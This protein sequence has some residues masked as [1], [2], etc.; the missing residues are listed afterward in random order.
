[1]LEDCNGNCC[2][3][4]TCRVFDELFPN[5]LKIGPDVIKG[6]TAFDGNTGSLPGVV[7]AAFGFASEL[8]QFSVDETKVG[9]DCLTEMND[10]D[11]FACSPRWKPATF[12]QIA[13]FIE[14]NP[15]GLWEDES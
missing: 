3:G 13:D 2:L 9:P 8:G 7:R 1:M 4:L 10:G 6:R 11:R 5:V 12:E 15:P 14:S